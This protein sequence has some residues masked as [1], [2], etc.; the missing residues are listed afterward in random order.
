MTPTCHFCKAG[1]FGVRAWGQRK[2]AAIG[3]YS[4]RQLKEEKF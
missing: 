4:S 3:L 2:P 1:L